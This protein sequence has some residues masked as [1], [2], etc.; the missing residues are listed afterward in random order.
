[1]KALHFFTFSI[2]T[3]KLT[4]CKLD[5]KLVSKQ[6]FWSYVFCFFSRLFI[7]IYSF[8]S[9][10][11]YLFGPLD[12]AYWTSLLK[13]IKNYISTQ[14]ILTFEQFFSG[15]SSHLQQ[16]QEQVEAS[17]HYTPRQEWQPYQAWIQEPLGR[18]LSSNKQTK[19]EPLRQRPL[20]KKIRHK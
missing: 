20:L 4:K 12:L 2:N 10:V 3:L 9:L 5:P 19:L 17:K 6:Y 1:M 7:F 13:S 8:G 11:F 16:A 15:E 14:F 18:R